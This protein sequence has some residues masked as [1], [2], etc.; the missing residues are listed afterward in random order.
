MCTSNS[1]ESDC[2]SVT[3]YRKSVSFFEERRK[4][5]NTNDVQDRFKTHLHVLSSDGP[6]YYIR[7][8]AAEL[9]VRAAAQSSGRD[10][11]CED[12]RRCYTIARSPCRHD[13]LCVDGQGGRQVDRYAP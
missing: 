1:P 6:R 3:R 10:R 5:R 2:L 7:V 11:I 8:Q 9:A 13:A 4:S 12:I